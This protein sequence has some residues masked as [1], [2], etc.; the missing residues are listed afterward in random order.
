MNL[1]IEQGP[2]H[3]GRRVIATILDYL[4]F[5]VVIAV[6]TYPLSAT[7]N[8]SFRGG[9]GMFTLN[10]CA[11]GQMFTK[12]NV[13]IKLTG[14]NGIQVCN[15]TIDF[16][17]PYR[18]GT[19]FKKSTETLNGRET[20]F[21]RSLSFQL[22]DQN[23]IVFPVELTLYA[24]FALVLLAAL[25]EYL[26]GYTPGKKVSGLLVETNQGGRLT[27]RSSVLRNILKYSLLLAWS[28]WSLIATPFAERV[29]KKS[30]QAD[31]TINMPV[32][33]GEDLTAIASY[34][35][36]DMA[37]SVAVSA[38]FLIV[39]L[40]MFIRWRKVKKGIHDRIAKTE[41]IRD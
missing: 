40:S 36:W 5:T 12:E 19:I 34:F 27:M 31:G 6:L 4:F 20:A 13:P 37:V 10:R 9:V 18:N 8:S 14:W 2:T 30:V 23:Q 26:L 11:E 35:V 39:P 15:T 29:L 25:S 28:I 16:V 22:N 3:L 1:R 7:L 24:P 41:V 33:F 32:E 38:I 17:F 21:T